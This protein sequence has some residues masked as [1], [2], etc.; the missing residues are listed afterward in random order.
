[1]GAEIVGNEDLA[2]DIVYSERRQ[3]FGEGR[4]RLTVLHV[5]DFTKA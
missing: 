5:G 4:E 3:P 1:V 2:L